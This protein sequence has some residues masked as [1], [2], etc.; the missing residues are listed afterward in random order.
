MSWIRGKGNEKRRLAKTYEAEMTHGYRF[1]LAKAYDIGTHLEVIK[2]TK[3]KI[4]GLH[5]K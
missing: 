1:Q 5:T 2:T 4:D 3:Y